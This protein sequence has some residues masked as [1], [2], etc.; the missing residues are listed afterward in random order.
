MGITDRT[1]EQVCAD[2]CTLRPI[3][4]YHEDMRNVLWWKIPIEEPPYCGTPNDSN[5]PSYHT[6]FSPLPPI[7]MLKVRDGR[8]RI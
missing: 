1:P 8:H 7:N 2:L 4:K 5:W 6:H 3:G